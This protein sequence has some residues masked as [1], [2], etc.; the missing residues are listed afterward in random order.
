MRTKITL[1]SF[2]CLFISS[3]SFAQTGST[4]AEPHLINSLPFSATGLTTQG[5]GNDY[6]TSGDCGGNNFM[7]G[8]DY[9]FSFTPTEY[10]S[11]NISLTDLTAPGGVGLYILDDCINEPTANCMGADEATTGEP[12]LS[13][14]GLIPGTTYYIFVSTFVYG[15]MNTFTGF[16]INIDP[17]VATTDDGGVTSISTAPSSCNLSDEAITVDITNFGNNTI[18]NF[19]LA[20]RINSGTEVVETYNGSIAPG[21]T[22]SHT[23]ATTADMSAPN[24][25]TIEAYT[26][27]ATDTVST[28]DTLSKTKTHGITISS[29]P[30][31]VDFESGTSNWFAEG[32]LN[33]WEYGIPSTSQT[34]NA[35]ASGSNCWVTN[36]YGDYNNE[37]S[38]AL[39]TPCFDFSAL[40]NPM[41]EMD[42]WYEMDLGTAYMEYS[43]NNGYN[44]TKV[45][46][47]EPVDAANWYNADNSGETGWNGQIA[48]DTWQTVHHT[49]ASLAGE[50]SVM[51]RIKFDGLTSGIT[52]NEGVAI[53]DFTIMEAPDNDLALLNLESPFSNCALGSEII[54]VNIQN[55]GDTEAFDIPIKYSL[56]NGTN[57]TNATITDTIQGGETYLYS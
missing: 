26:S 56:D 27:I 55:L 20:Y 6:S 23:F 4:C 46:E 14:I 8:E 50:P 7:T 5:A 29:F 3:L 31:S 45:G 28:N 36:L 19:D 1:L 22:Y 32:Y 16:S 17:I 54:S 44:W 57:Y 33:S 34:I 30:Y 24:S 49:L 41:V 47:G 38:S 10:V 39:Y 48:G 37:E 52:L 42:I 18:S 35:A 12:S 43:L 21:M 2:I 51:F 13:Q 53:D 9:V 11:V 15:T 25:Y 40:L